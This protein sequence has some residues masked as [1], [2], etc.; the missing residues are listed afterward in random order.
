MKFIKFPPI[1]IKIEGMENISIPK[2]M[3]IKQ[4]YDKKKIDD[5]EGFVK[6]QME[7][8]LRGTKRFAGKKICITAGSRGIPHLDVIIKSIADKLKQ[9]GAEPF[10]IPAMGSHGG[11]TAEG[12]KEM[13]ATYNITEESIGAPVRA[14]MDVARIGNL[15]DGTPVYCDKFAYESDGVVILNK[16]KPHT[17]F[18]GEYESGMAKMMSIGLANHKGASMF[19]MMG[20]PSFPKRIP[21]VCEVFL[22]NASIA[23][24][25]GIVQNAYDDISEIEVMEKEFLLERD[26]ELLKIAKKKIATFKMPQ[27]DVLVID[28]IG[29]NISGN[30]HD[31]N[32]TGR[33]NSQ[34]FEDVIDLKKLF[35]RSLNEET[36]HNGAGISAADVTTRRCLESVDYETMW[37]N[38]VTSTMLNGGKTPMY[39]ENDRDALMLCI[40]TCN[41]IDFNRAKVVRIKD[42]LSM[43]FIEVS[44]SYYDELKDNPEVEILS[45][46]REM[47]FDKD[48]F[49]L[50]DYALMK[51]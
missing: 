26:R 46:P 37:I 48:G 27:I 50:N 3:K 15:A 45:E 4:I 49:M 16:V 33:G 44:E 34:G 2:M 11:A 10:I 36:H 6:K 19:H 32:I 31:P 38:N 29:K 47:R 14:T 7:N 35:I 24:G 22:K 20:F 12:Q 18:R 5:I 51:E 25:V 43:E 41:G 30:G 21:E 8:N 28:E 42:T 9:W 1:P 23:F 13:I 17:D 39:T 40:R